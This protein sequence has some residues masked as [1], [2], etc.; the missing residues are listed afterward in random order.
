MKVLKFGGSSVSTPTNLATIVSILQRGQQH[1]DIAAIVVSALSGVTDLLLQAAQQATSDETACCRTISQLHKIHSTLIEQTLPRTLQPAVLDW[2][3]NYI[4][5]L[6]CVL[7]Q[8]TTTGVCTTEQKDSVAAYGEILS[9]HI[10]TTLL[11]ANEVNATFI[12]AREIIQTNDQF[13]AAAVD[14]TTTYALIQKHCIDRSCIYIIPGFIA[15][16]DS[17][18]TTTLGRGGSDYTAS[19]IGSALNVSSIEIWTDVHGVMTADPRMV[20]NALPLSHLSYEEAM[21][22]SRFGA[23]VI[24]PP[25]ITPA[26]RAGIPLCIKN[27]LNPIFPG[28]LIHHSPAENNNALIGIASIPQLSLIRLTHVQRKDTEVM[29]KRLHD[30][31]LSYPIITLHTE[32]SESTSIH[33]ICITP[34]HAQRVLDALMIVFKNELSDPAIA[35][36]QLEAACALVTLVL[37]HRASPR[38]QLSQVKNVLGQHGIKPLTFLEHPDASSISVIIAQPEHHRALNLLHERF[39]ENYQHPVSDSTAFLA[40]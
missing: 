15:R 25:T 36:I 11:Q 18:A 21:E 2:I 10:I 23:K 29:P 32:T 38:T 16:A 9:S 40:A 8:I 33:N 39:F 24:Y 37:H 7:R 28:T 26:Y 4:D 1:H 27:T 5:Q 31:L 14:I 19:L 35:S 12:D 13:G 17:G 3:S 22:L 30:T 20:Q 34:E 6:Q